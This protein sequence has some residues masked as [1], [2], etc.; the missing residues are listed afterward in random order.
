[1]EL[2]PFLSLTRKEIFVLIRVP[3]DILRA[4]ADRTNFY[5]KLDPKEIEI[6]GKQGDPERGIAP[7]E[8]PHDENVTVYPPY[9]YIY[10]RFT[11]TVPEKLFAR[12]E[13]EKDPFEGIN[14]IKLTGMLI[15]SRPLGNN[16]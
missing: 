12:R 6:A 10:S 16:S 7:F 15:E 5:M 9:E 14:K 13:G 11:R 3:N 2:F 1:M 4:F 8:I